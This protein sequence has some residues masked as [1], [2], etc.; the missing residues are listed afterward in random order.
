MKINLLRS[1]TESLCSK[2]NHNI[3]IPNMRDNFVMM[4]DGDNWGLVDRTE[5]LGYIFDNS[6]GL[7]VIKNEEMQDLYGE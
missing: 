1:A 5:A 7:M 4:Y 2:E 6:H 3:Y